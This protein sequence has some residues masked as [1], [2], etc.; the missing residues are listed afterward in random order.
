MRLAV[1]LP[2][3]PVGVRIRGEQMSTTIPSDKRAE[4]RAWAEQEVGGD[5]RAVEAATDAVLAALVRG[6]TIDE[7]MSV[8][9]AAGRVPGNDADPGSIRPAH[10]VSDRAHV[11]GQVAAFRQR[12]E[13]MGRRYGSIWDF[14]VDSWD[15]AGQPQ[16]PVAV[17]IR[18][19]SIEGSIGD[20]DWVEISGHPS[21]GRVLKVRRLRNISMNALVVA[22]GGPS[23]GRPWRFVKGLMSLVFAAGFAALIIFIAV[24]IY[25]AGHQP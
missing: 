18:A 12:N 14:R 10:P 15:A 21:A 13:L 3:R 11:R 8:G 17:E 1:E 19:L 9:R 22:R 7:A 24:S 23:S 16:P 5:P 6:T 20:G 4:W 2:V 25:Q